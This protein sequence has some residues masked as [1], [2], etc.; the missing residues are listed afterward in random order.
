MNTKLTSIKLDTPIAISKD[1][2]NLLMRV[3]AGMVAGRKDEN[4]QHFIKVWYKSAI[5]YVEKVINENQK[6]S[7]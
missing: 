6:P 1:Q 5:P 7:E 2:Y 4:D 3:F